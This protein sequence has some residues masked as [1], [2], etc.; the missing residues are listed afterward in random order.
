[1]A[2]E[3]RLQRIETYRRSV[4]ASRRGVPTSGDGGRVARA[5]RLSV[6][7]GRQIA[8]SASRLRE[9]PGQQGRGAST[10]R[11]R[12]HILAVSG[13]PDPLGPAIRLI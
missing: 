4:A 3:Q 9:E 8:E 1:V 6:D 7:L 12:R 11:E 2:I 13:D 5:E 10:G